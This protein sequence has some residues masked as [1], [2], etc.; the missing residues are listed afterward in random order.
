VL[1][2]GIAVCAGL[3]T[4]YLGELGASIAR[5]GNTSDMRRYREALDAGEFGTVRVVQM[6]GI[7]RDVAR[8]LVV[9]AVGLILAAGIVVYHVPPMTLRGAILV[10]VLVIGAAMGAAGDGVL[11]MV[12]ERR[13][14]WWFGVGVA[15][16]LA[17]VV[18]T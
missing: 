7:A 5:R 16:G 18:V 1:G 9:T 8:S 15:V 2:T 13:G 14:L 3:V 4:A 17:W 6:R 12:G 11:R 10:T